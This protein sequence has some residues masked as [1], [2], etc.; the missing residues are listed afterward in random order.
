LTIEGSEARADARRLIG[1]IASLGGGEILSRALAFLAL[2]Y[3]ARVLEPEGLGVI[4]F[5]AAFTVYMSIAIR[6]GY[7]DIGARE[8][9]RRPDAA[10]AIASSAILVRLAIAAGLWVL[11]CGIAVLL[12]RPWEVKLVLVIAGLSFFTLALD[13]SW[14][15]KGLERNRPVAITM[16]L[17]QI[18]YCGLVFFAVHGPS[19]VYLVPLAQFVGEFAAAVALVALLFSGA[20][21]DWTLREGFALLKQAGSPIALRA[22]RLVLFAFDVILLGFVRSE[23]EVGLY[24]APYRI[25]F[26]LLAIGTAIG[27]S[28]LPVISRAA[29]AGAERVSRVGERALHLCVALAAPVAVGAMIV[30]EP[31]VGTLFGAEYLEGV[32]AFRIVLAGASV[33]FLFGILHN[34]LVACDRL[35]YEVG[36]TAVA[37]AL[38]IGLNVALV[39]GYGIVGAAVASTIPDFTLFVGGLAAVRAC[40]IRMRL[41]PLVRPLLAAGAMGAVVAAL[42]PNRSLA[43]YVAVGAIVYPLAL[44]LLGGIPEDLR[45]YLGGVAFYRRTTH[46]KQ[47]TDGGDR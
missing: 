3:L 7:M 17:S 27:A 5:A 21:L 31:L 46:E 11:L 29:V 18:L 33:A 2:A 39:P 30:A 14:V 34:V 15:F 45:S 26:L 44:A 25:C 41:S 40:G 13:T 47:Q 24:T 6:A 16:L 43:L 20:R 23:R 8:V 10:A 35:R 19:D 1:N 32:T 38:N 22:L 12:E 4:S 37:A 42:G 9:A 36:I 28:Y